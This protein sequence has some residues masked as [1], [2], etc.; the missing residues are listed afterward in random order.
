MANSG[1]D[2]GRGP[3]VDFRVLAGGQTGADRGALDAALDAGVPC[4]GWCPA[5]RWAEDG[6]IAARYPLRETP[7][8]DPLVRT[9]RNVADADGTLVL[10]LGAPDAGTQATVDAAEDLGRPW[11]EID[12][13]AMADEAAALKIAAWIGQV[14][15]RT[16][17]VAGPRESKAPGLRDRVRH[18]LGAVLSMM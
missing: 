4:G 5:G 12:L 13:S 9:R 18:V 14:P 2:A 10:T 6:P 15:I 16:L 1:G 17:N 7:E 3:A 8:T 11:L